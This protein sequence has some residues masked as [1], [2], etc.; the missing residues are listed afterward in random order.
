MIVTRVRITDASRR[1]RAVLLV[2]SVLLAA[3]TLGARAL[4]GPRETIVRTIV[5]G[6]LPDALALDPDSGH[7]VVADDAAATVSVLDLDS[8]Q[9]LHTVRVGDAAADAPLALALDRATHRLFVANRGDNGAP[10]VLRMLDSRSGAPLVTRRVGSEA[11]AVAV[12]ERAGHA[13]VATEGDG[14]VSMLNART[15]AALRTTAL[16]Q[17]PLAMATDA[18]TA[19]V[20]VGGPVTPAWTHGATT[21]RISVLDTR[22]GT[23]VRTVL[24]ATMP[25]ALAVDVRTERAFAATPD[26]NAVSMLDARSGRVLRTIPLG[27]HPS[28]LAVDER[29]GRVYVVNAG[30][31]S[32]SILDA[33]TGQV[34][35]THPLVPPDGA[36]GLAPYALAVD[37]ARDRV[38]VTAGGRLDRDGVFQ[39]PGRLFV[40]D[41]H[42]GTV[43][44]TLAVGLAPQTL[45]VETRSGRVVVV[46]SGGAVSVKTDGAERWLRPVLGGLPWLRRIALPPAA[47]AQVPGMVRVIDAPA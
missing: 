43:R 9:I 7:A 47:V 8:G 13:F 1:S 5:I 16:D 21:G 46:E 31:G 30:D 27:G 17:A 24:V 38:Y 18:H 29:R 33:R 20:F 22:S 40:L 10:S 34:L 11:S 42:N 28:A 14:R 26:S 25:V 36:L 23:L 2:L 35:Q 6:R 4:S 37:E 19:R 45:A 41:A 3:G 44:R 39:G 32:V 12:D 15:G